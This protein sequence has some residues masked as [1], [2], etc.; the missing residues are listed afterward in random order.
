MAYQVHLFP[1]HSQAEWV[2]YI[3]LDSYWGPKVPDWEASP[4]VSA[5]CLVASWV[6]IRAGEGRLSLDQ[7]GAL[8]ADIVLDKDREA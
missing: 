7:V 4:L 2:V 8:A 5:S 3:R 6:N 1:F